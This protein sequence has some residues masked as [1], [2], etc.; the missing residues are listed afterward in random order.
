MNY[1]KGMK[2]KLALLCAMMHDP[3]VLI[4]DEPTNGLDPYATRTLI[5]IVKEKV[6]EG[7]T[8]FY[9]THLL[10]QAEKLCHR[11][12]IVFKGRLAAAGTLEE[13]RT[14]LSKGGSLEEIF[15]AVTGGGEPAA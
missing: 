14:R 10:D 5:E 9:S 12:G 1:S 3:Q 15:F 6:A 2:K 4:L 11:V 7:K 8:V 13:L